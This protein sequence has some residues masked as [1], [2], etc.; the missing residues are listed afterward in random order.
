MNR[1]EQRLRACQNKRYDDASSKL[2]SLTVPNEAM[3]IPYI[4][5]RYVKGMPLPV[6]KEA[7]NYETDNFDS[8]DWEKMKNAD[9]FDHEEMREELK[10]VVRAA[11]EQADQRKKQKAKV[12]EPPVPTP[13]PTPAPVEK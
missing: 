5:S 3:T 1:R 6:S 11:E 13:E 9:M 12:T 7:I 2:P 4:L 8:P 10:E